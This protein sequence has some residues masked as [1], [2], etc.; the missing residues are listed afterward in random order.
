VHLDLIGTG[1]FAVS[2]ASTAGG[3]DV[4]QLISAGAVGL[5]ATKLAGFLFYRALQTNHDARLK[6]ALS[7]TGGALGF[8]AISALWGVV[9]TLPH[10]IAAGVVPLARPAFG[11][12]G[13]AGLLVFL[14]GLGL[15]TAAD[16]QKWTFK[17]EV[18]NKGKFCDRGV[19]QLSQHPNW[20]GNVLLWSGIALLNLP[21]LLAQGPSAG[22]LLAGVASPCFML[23]LFYGQATDSLART[24]A[25]ADER[26]GDDPRYQVYVAQTPLL[27]PNLASVRRWSTAV[28]DL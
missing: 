12:V 25:L 5:W 6:E 26:Y 19:W 8:W 13:A 18:A 23:A 17:S 24:K 9:V 10:T 2:A 27:V 3:G 1:I 7:T 20:M 15:E 4:R 11:A 28:C 21:V 14:A 22:R 16:Y